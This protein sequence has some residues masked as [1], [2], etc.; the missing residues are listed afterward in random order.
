MRKR[1]SAIIESPEKMMGAVNQKSIACFFDISL[2]NYGVLLFENGMDITLHV[3]APSAGRMITVPY[4]N[5][6]NQ[7]FEGKSWL[8]YPDSD[9]TEMWFLMWKLESEMA[10]NFNTK[11][12]HHLTH[13]LSKA[14][15][16]I[17]DDGDYG[18]C[19]DKNE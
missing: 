2:P 13:R 7:V 9:I 1:T 19:G 5:S 16:R 4:Y 8:I 14:S 17:T 6:H 3:E 11:I 15:S 12:I 18:N 10:H